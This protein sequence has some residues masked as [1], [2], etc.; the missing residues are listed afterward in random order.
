MNLLL[1]CARPRSDAASIRQAAAAVADWD[2]TI[3]LSMRHGIAPIVYWRV[4]Q[5][6]PEI[7][8]P[9]AL[10]RLLTCFHRNA[11]HSLKLTG[12]LLKLVALL[13]RAGIQ[14]VPFKGPAIAWSL[15]DSPALREMSDL[16]LLVR[17][18]DARRAVDL[19]VASG[20]Q[21]E[22]STD[23]RFLRSAR[24]LHLISPSGVN[25]D[26]HWDMAPP[27]FRNALDLEG[28]W[29]RL[30]TVSVAGRSIRT[31][32]TEDL[33]VFLCVHG[34]K[35]FWCSLHWLCDLARLIDKAPLDWDALMAYSRARRI[36]CTVSAGVLL[37]ADVLGAAVPPATLAGARACPRTSRIA[38]RAQLW[39]NGRPVP[40]VT[41]PSE[42]RFQLSLL[43]RPSDKLR[44][45]WS[46]FAPAPT[47]VESLTLPR[48]LFPVYYASRPLRLIAKYS[49]LAVR[50]LFS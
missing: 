14:V 40:P 48:P 24:E 45:C 20:C 19:L 2:A 25:L 32:A 5:A 22:Y 12:E 42:F 13:E 27:W 29:S 50:R 9:A 8:P 34:S 30:V 31:L 4:S 18:A 43:E 16:D 33:L 26:L 1:E 3:E 37:A 17:P 38:S 46:L 6:C 10:E 47:D 44:L 21:P 11:G 49:G 15:Y 23:F 28:F 36:S 7:V 41:M 39:L 35:H